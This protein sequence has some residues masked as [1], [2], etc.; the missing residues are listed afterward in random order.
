[1]EGLGFRPGVSTKLTETLIRK[2]LVVID[3]LELMAI[4]VGGT[5][6][7]GLTFLAQPHSEAL[8]GPGLIQHQCPEKRSEA[9][10]KVKC[11]R[12]ELPEQG[13]PIIYFL[14]PFKGFQRV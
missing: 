6:S 7:L 9:F 10:L 12:G 3:N 5:A 4:Q 13:K 14:P 11:A 8:F 1:M 2:T